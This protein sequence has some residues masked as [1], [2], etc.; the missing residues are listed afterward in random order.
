MNG[1]VGVI[2]V[3]PVVAVCCKVRR[4]AGGTLTGVILYAGCESFISSA[5]C[6]SQTRVRRE[7]VL[8]DIKNKGGSCSFAG[9][10]SNKAERTGV[11]L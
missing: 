10:R 1:T 4:R 11:L 5:A 6:K 2:T 8:E 9:C 3:V 7:S